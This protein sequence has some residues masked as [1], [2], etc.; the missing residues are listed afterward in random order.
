MALELARSGADLRG[1][2]SFHGG[3]DTAKP[4][5]TRGIKAAV[6]V[7]HGAD[8]PTVPQEAVNGIQE[9]MR[10]AG[11]DWQMV[12]YGD[13]VHSFS[14]PDSGT[15]KSKGVKYDAKADKRSWQH[16]RSFLEEVLAP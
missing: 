5:D 8:D 12:F 4:G 15:D 7:L 13:A 14:N 16:M 10:K 6:L 2:V 9:E 11:A 1:A 3:L